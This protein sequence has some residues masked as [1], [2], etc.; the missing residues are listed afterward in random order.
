MRGVWH[1]HTPLFREKPVK[2]CD[3]YKILSGKVWKTLGEC[4]KIK[5]IKC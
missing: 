2:N 5:I 1:C 4:A 3:L